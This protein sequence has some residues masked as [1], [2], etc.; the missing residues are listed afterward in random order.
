MKSHISRL[1]SVWTKT[2]RK[3]S[4]AVAESDSDTTLGLEQNRLCRQRQSS[5]ELK[6]KMKSDSSRQYRYD[7]DSPEAKWSATPNV[8]VRR[9]SI[10]FSIFFLY[11]TEEKKEKRGRK[12]Y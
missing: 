6:Q 8:A 3:I 10:L 9:Y 11:G 7:D 2:R 1:N 4:L 12:D 5:T